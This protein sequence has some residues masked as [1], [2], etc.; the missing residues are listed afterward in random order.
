MKLHCLETIYIHTCTVVKVVSMAYNM[1]IVYIYNVSLSIPQRTIN[2]NNRKD[3]VTEIT[4]SM[5]SKDG[6]NGRHLHG[7]TT[8]E[9][10]THR[11]R[12][13]GLLYNAIGFETYRPSNKMWHQQNTMVLMM[14]S[15]C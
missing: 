12:S 2:H 7:G 6:F 8:Y 13:H 5:Y 10:R 9:Y 3:K 1:D 11:A 14:K 4:Y 15:N